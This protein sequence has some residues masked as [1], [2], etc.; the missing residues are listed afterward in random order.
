MGVYEVTQEQ[1]EAVTGKNPSKFKGPNNPVE[2]VSWEDVTAFCKKLSDKTRKTVRPPTEAE[3]EYTCR[4]GS[5]TA[6]CFGNDASNLSDYAWFDQNS[7]KKT[8]PVGLKKPNA[9]GLYDMHGNVWEWCSDWQNS[10]ANLPAGKAGAKN[11]DPQGPASGVNRVMRGGCV[12][13]NRW[14]CRSARRGWNDPDYQH[15]ICL[16]FRVVVDSK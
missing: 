3:W 13:F 4:A 1:Y 6:Y 10:Y 5:K 11:V 16:G 12:H 15:V 9:F 2:M 14:D 7:D 8:H